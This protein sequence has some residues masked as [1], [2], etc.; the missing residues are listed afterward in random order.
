M[1]AS[2]I[3]ESIETDRE[4]SVVSSENMEPGSHYD[5]ARGRGIKSSWNGSLNFHEMGQSRPTKEYRSQHLTDR[6]VSS[7]D[8]A[9]RLVTIGLESNTE[10]RTPP[11]G[12]IHE[13]RTE[14]RPPAIQQFRSLPK[15]E[16]KHSVMHSRE[17]DVEAGTKDASIPGPV[18]A[19]PSTS[20]IYTTDAPRHDAIWGPV[21]ILLLGALFATFFIVY[22]HTSVP[23]GKFGDTI[24]STLRSSFHLFAIDTMVSV[25][26]S[27]V[28]L[29]FLNT[30]LKP[31]VSIIL[32]AVPLVS[33]YFS[34]LSF[35]ASSGITTV[36]GQGLRWL[37][38]LPAVCAVVWLYTIYKGRR[39][40]TKAISILHFACR[41]LLANPALLGLGVSTMGLIIIWTW[42][43]LLMFS[44]VF[45]GGHFTH[46]LA[47]FVVNTTSWWLATYFILLYIWSLSII[48][49]VQRSTTAATVSQWYFHRNAIPTPSSREIVMAALNHA[50]RTNFGTICL[51]TLFSVGIRVPLMILPRRVLSVIS[52]C[53]YTVMPTPLMS[54]VNPLTITYAAIHSQS[55]QQSARGLSQMSFMVP[56]TPVNTLTPRDFSSRHRTSPPLLPYRLAQLILH[57]T[58]II[59]SIALG[60]SG[61]VATARDLSVHLPEGKATRGSASAYMVGIVASLIGWSVL[62]AMEGLL[63]AIVDACVICWGSEKA[64][65]GG[66]AY[67]LE[68]GYL[69]GDDVNAR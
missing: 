27:L 6:N 47:G 18:N 26:A 17:V 10:H 56:Q 52:M 33:I 28:W 34:V 12:S 2:R 58:R 31:L 59:M 14:E 4:S 3:D 1:F 25:L 35:K 29:A 62:G 68:A 60:Y 16:S 69:F 46:G 19:V 67:C 42:T 41:I 13:K 5:R 9:E 44:R 53:A 39:A 66:G 36:Q 48:V 8:E 32:F 21:F 64:M 45:L 20:N 57:A 24:Y 50:I 43:W 15:A 51:S 23:S 55:L 38:V 63:G 61:W 11:D 49:G 40:L 65:L 30:L 37:S 7:G 54:L 22:L